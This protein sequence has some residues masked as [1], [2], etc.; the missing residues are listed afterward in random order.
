MNTDMIDFLLRDSWF[1]KKY[2]AKSDGR[3]QTLKAA[4]NLYLQADGKTILETGCVRQL[5]D[6]GAGYSTV[7]FCEV[8]E[9]FGGHLWSVDINPRNVAFCEKTTQQW[10]G[11]RNVICSDS[12]AFLENFTEKIDLLYLDSWDYP[13]I[14]LLDIYGDR[15]NPESALKILSTMTDDEIAERHADMIMPSQ[16]H[17]VKELEASLHLLTPNSIILIDDNAFPGGG[18]S[19]LAKRKLVELGW[20]IINDSQQTLWIKRSVKGGCCG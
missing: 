5:D 8:L 20:T 12:V 10:D 9:K 14:E 17:C 6:F 3:F 1:E 15:H 16:E 13:Y 18:K 2:A 4:I 11:L 7:L 19:R